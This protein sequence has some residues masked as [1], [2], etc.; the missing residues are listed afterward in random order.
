MS[1][2]PN[3]KSATIYWRVVDSCLH[4]YVV[5]KTHKLGH[6]SSARRRARSV[7]SVPP[8]CKPLRRVPEGKTIFIINTL[9]YPLETN[10]KH[11]LYK[12]TCESAVG[13]VARMADTS[14]FT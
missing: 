9:W 8:V 11:L 4:L 14:G 6:D 10:P 13:L 2:E 5:L 12:R 3:Q 7:A 1:F